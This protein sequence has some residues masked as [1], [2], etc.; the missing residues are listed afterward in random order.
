MSGPVAPFAKEGLRP[1][2]D[3]RGSQWVLLPDNQ[4]WLLP[5]IQRHQKIV[6]IFGP[7]GQIDVKVESPPGDLPKLIDSFYEMLTTVQDGKVTISTIEAYASLLGLVR[8]LINH[9]Y[10][11]PDDKYVQLLTVNKRQIAQLF[12]NLVRLLAMTG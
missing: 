5:V 7:D 3:E 11:L 10:D 6:P 2:V 12:N 1:G 9:N 4:Q 8:A